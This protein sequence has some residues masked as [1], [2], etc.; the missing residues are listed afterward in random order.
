VVG[1]KPAIGSRRNRVSNTPSK[2]ACASGSLSTAGFY[3]TKSR[4][5]LFSPLLLN[6]LIQQ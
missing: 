2:T 3:Q 4:S 5:I 1:S 6:S